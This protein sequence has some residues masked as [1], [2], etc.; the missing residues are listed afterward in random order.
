MTAVVELFLARSPGACHNRRALFAE[1][2]PWT[3]VTP[4]RSTQKIWVQGSGWSVVRSNLS[5]VQNPCWLMVRSGSTT[6]I[7]PIHPSTFG[8]ITTYCMKSQSCHVDSTT[9]V[10]SLD[11][12]SPLGSAASFVDFQRYSQ[13]L[14]FAALASFLTKA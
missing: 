13:D 1:L 3:W 9:L 6:N 7:Y 5:S 10:S 2:S 11:L 4:V 12:P 8:I 14:S